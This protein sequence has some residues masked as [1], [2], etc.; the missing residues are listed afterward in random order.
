MFSD[1]ASKLKN[2]A[3][4]LIIQQNIHFITGREFFNN[5]ERDA[6]LS[7]LVKLRDAANA[8][9]SIL[10][11]QA[12]YLGVSKF[13]LSGGDGHTFTDVLR[14]INDGQIKTLFVFVFLY[15][16]EILIA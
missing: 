9:L 15:S 7:S 3:N 4:D 5:P 16:G 8:K 6:L 13:G 12:N 11:T 10:P 1:N 14:K 2:L